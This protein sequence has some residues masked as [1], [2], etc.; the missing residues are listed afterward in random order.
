MMHYSCR[1]DLHIMSEKH[2]IVLTGVNHDGLQHGS[3]ISTSLSRL[4]LE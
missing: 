3:F 2:R 4:S 1:V